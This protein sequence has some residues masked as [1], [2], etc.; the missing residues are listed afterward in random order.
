MELASGSK[1]KR[2]PRDVT[3]KARLSVTTSYI[4]AVLLRCEKTE[5]K[6]ARRPCTVRSDLL[7]QRQ[8]SLGNSGD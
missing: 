2:H 4:Q 1:L 5:E 7:E 3:H 6:P 8:H